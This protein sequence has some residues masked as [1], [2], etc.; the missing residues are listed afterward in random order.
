MF[1]CFSEIYRL[2]VCHYTALPTIY[3]HTV[4]PGD[5]ESLAAVFNIH[6]NMLIMSLLS[7]LLH[8][9]PFHTHT[10][11]EMDTVDLCVCFLHRVLVIDYF[12]WFCDIV[13]LAFWLSCFV[14]VCVCVKSTMLIFCFGLSVNLSCIFCALQSV[15]YLE[16]ESSCEED[17]VLHFAAGPDAFMYLQWL[18]T[19][20]LL[21]LFS[22]FCLC[23]RFSWFKAALHSAEEWGTAVCTLPPC[24]LILF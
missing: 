1:P 24:H 3:W 17:V 21:S 9:C 6:V 16:D 19:C 2:T 11:R 15:G 13:S 12:L 10:K 4:R 18:Q 8:A 23:N 7:L 14:C 5:P 20:S 22:K